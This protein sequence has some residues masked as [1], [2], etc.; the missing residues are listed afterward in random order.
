M[1]STYTDAHRNACAAAIAALG[2]RVGLYTSAGARVGT[3]FADT[4]WGAAAKVTEDG[5]DWGKVNGSQVTITVP[6][7]TVA[8]G[9]QITRYGIHNGTTLLRS[10]DLPVGLTINDGDVAFS[11]DVTPSFR[12]RGI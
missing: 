11:V 5:F 4:T 10:E 9:T 8:D 1:A 12:Y 7:G 2:N 3:V 6:A